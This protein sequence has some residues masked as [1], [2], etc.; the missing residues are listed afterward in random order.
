MLLAALEQLARMDA[1]T[2]RGYTRVDKEEALAQCSLPGARPRQ[3]CRLDAAS[4]ARAAR[5][6]EP[7]RADVCL[8][9][10]RTNHEPRSQAA[11]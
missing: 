1:D 7:G 8:E 4:V 10:R 9:L 5:L 6:G 3:G 11:I 2:G